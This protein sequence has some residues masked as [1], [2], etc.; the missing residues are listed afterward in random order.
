MNKREQKKKLKEV[1]EDYV[2]KYFEGRNG[3]ICFVSFEYIDLE[4]TI[5]L[6]YIQIGDGI[7]RKTE[8]LEL[9]QKHFNRQTDNDA[10]NRALMRSLASIT[11]ELEPFN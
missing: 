2:H 5:C 6:Y 11:R 9:F 10:F 4:G 3:E 8:K 7:C 1:S